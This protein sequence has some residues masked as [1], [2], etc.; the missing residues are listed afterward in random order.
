MIRPAS[1]S[2]S[3]EC[4]THSFDQDGVCNYC[5]FKTAV[6][7]VTFEC[8]VPAELDDGAAKESAFLQLVNRAF[9]AKVA[10]AEKRVIENCNHHPSEICSKC[11]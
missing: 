5:G 4:G 7:K 9:P 1:P 3:N 2:P 10:T 11:F 8:Y 6:R